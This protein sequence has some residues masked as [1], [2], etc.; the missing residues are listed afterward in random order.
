MPKKTLTACLTVLCLSQVSACG[1]TSPAEM[2]DG[3]PKQSVDANSIPDAVPKKEPLSQY[4]NAKTYQVN[5][6]TYQTLSYAGN[7]N[8]VGN[9]SWYGT[10]FHGQ[11]TSTREKFNMYAMTAASTELPLP[12]YVKVTNLENGKNVI[13]KVNDRGPF[14]KNRI[15]DLSYVAAKKLGFA[16]K[17]TALVRVAVVSSENYR[18]YNRSHSSMTKQHILSK[19][20]YLQVGSFTSKKNAYT[21]QARVAKL[22]KRKVQV[23]VK[24]SNNLPVYHVKVGPITTLAEND[25]LKKT[26]ANNGITGAVL[27]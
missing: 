26:L 22:T 20:S 18:A 2:R 1:P 23:D 11:Y 25:K 24:R 7:Y 10:K 6:H 5:G 21:M 4:G 17:G 27:R 9:A 14:E 12:S 19:P 8:K 13:V 15:L 3:P 16:S